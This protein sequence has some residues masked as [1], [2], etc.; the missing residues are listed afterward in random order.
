MSNFA[1]FVQAVGKL[2]LLTNDLP[3]ARI[4]ATEAVEAGIAGLHLHTG[5]VEDTDLVRDPFQGVSH[6]LMSF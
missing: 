3:T 1:L 4:T 2:S 6:P 5:G